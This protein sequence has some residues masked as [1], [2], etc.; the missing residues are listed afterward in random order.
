MSCVFIFC[1]ESNTG[2]LSCGYIHNQELKGL[3]T[4]TIVILSVF[5]FAS[6]SF[7]FN[8]FY[9]LVLFALYRVLLKKFRIPKE[10]QSMY[11]GMSC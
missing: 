11:C 7:L 5:F 9:Q 8:N 2:L 1:G 3:V 4:D 10:N 6:L